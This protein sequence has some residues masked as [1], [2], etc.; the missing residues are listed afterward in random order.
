MLL[1]AT[2]YFKG[3][4]YDWIVPMEVWFK[5]PLPKMDEHFQGP[6]LCGSRTKQ[7]KTKQLIV[8]KRM[9]AYIVV[10]SY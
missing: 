9:N 1:D 3:K 10:I 6:K 2:V 7:N 4:N 5:N 8:P